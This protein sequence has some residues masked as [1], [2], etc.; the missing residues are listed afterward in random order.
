MHTIVLRAGARRAGG[1]ARVFS[2]AILGFLAMLSSS[3]D[4]LAE[5]L[6]SGFAHTCA[7]TPLGGVKCWGDNTYFGLGDGTRNPTSLP[8]DVLGLQDRVTDIAVGAFYS[9]A[10]TARGAV[11]CWGYG[12]NGQVGIGLETVAE[13]PALVSG[14]G[15]GMR[16]ITAGPTHACALTDAGDVLCWGNNEF[17]QLGD[18]TEA[19]SV[20][21]VPVSGLGPGTLAIA[22]GADHSCALTAARGVKCWGRN[23]SGQLGDGTFAKRSTPV[24][25][26][27]LDSGVAAVSLAVGHSCA[28]T[29]VGRVKCWG[30]N[31]SGELGNG[32][33]SSS[34]PVP[35]DATALEDAAIAIVTAYWH[36]C[37]LTGRGAVKCWGS[38][39]DGQL[40]DG[41]TNDRS[42][43]VE[44][45]GLG[46]GVVALAAGYSHTCARLRTGEL[47][48]WG[49]G[50]MNQL[51]NGIPITR[52]VPT[53]VVGLGA[54]EVEVAT[55]E[56][57]ACAL[58]AD[59]AASCWGWNSFGELGD[60]TTSPRS[61]ASA[62]TGIGSPLTAV[63][64]GVAHSCAITQ[65]NAVWC[66]GFG[67]FGQL[68][69]GYREN[70]AAPVATMRL[71]GNAAELAL[72]Y[73]HSCAL[74]LDGEVRCWGNNE[75]GQLG[76]GNDIEGR[77]SP[78][79]VIELGPGVKAI[80]AGAYHSCAI[81]AAGGV[82][83]WGQNASGELGDGT[84][85]NRNKPV[86]VQGLGTDV[87]AISAH[88]Q[89]TCALTRSRA[90][91]CWG[92]GAPAIVDVAGLDGEIIMIAAGAA[93]GCALMGGG[94]LKC[95]GANHYGQLGD[96]TRDYRPNAVGVREASSGVSRVAAGD[97]NTCAIVAGVVRCWG[98][99][100]FGQVG[101]GDVGYALVPQ[102]VVGSPFTSVPPR[103]R[104]DALRLR[105]HR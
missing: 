63:A 51:G 96:G 101:N 25:V 99:T 86:D 14:L 6:S 52:E 16:A 72:G 10:L 58:S 89:Q 9:C 31:G 26:V 20:V 12:L 22:A 71:D 1:I 5:S 40:G 36:T 69:D 42:G 55:A 47:R 17:G 32:T 62:V 70:R 77:S 2:I 92:N 78:L 27:G 3:R 21:P 43:A 60:G 44:V 28:L 30:G 39:F 105:S 95:W 13:R 15:A 93:H 48:C 34:S 81:T 76:V 91:R 64:T 68:G 57:H 49:S 11:K 80:A 104:S 7:I 84:T 61:T 37:A 23:E 65:G 24:N 35:V 33:P 53:D 90:V 38:N 75:V 4:A 73:V 19:N 102:K 103:L 46:S 97:R 74:T 29:V 100:V 8:V 41:T 59:G 83:C 87:V 82:K 54:S 88:A 18:G 56:H 45:E 79:P 66:W 67:A 85:T 50:S 94:S 98:S